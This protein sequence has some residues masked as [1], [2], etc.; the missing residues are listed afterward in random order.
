MLRNGFGADGLQP[1]RMDF[2]LL[3][4]LHCPAFPCPRGFRSP[5]ALRAR[6]ISRMR[7]G[8]TDDAGEST[9]RKLSGN[10]RVQASSVFLASA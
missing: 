4:S 10:I 6:S 9:A 3:G 5:V 7:F 8:L 1:S 2:L